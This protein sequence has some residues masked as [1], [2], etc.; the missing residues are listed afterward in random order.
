MLTFFLKL[1]SDVLRDVNSMKDELNITSARKALIRCG[2]GEQPNGLWEVK[3]LVPNLQNIVS[4]YQNSSVQSRI[5][6]A[7]ALSVV[8][9][10]PICQII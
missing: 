7:Y 4:K 3:K 9:V 1:D 6:I 10:L 2:F 5:T 8:S